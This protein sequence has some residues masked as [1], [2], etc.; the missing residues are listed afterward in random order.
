MPYITIDKNGKQITSY[1]GYPGKNVSGA[2]K[3][4][5][6]SPTEYHVLKIDY[7][8]FYMDEQWEISEELK[9]VADRET[10][11]KEEY[12]REH[13]NLIWNEVKK[14]KKKK[15]SA[16]DLIEVNKKIK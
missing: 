10:L 15:L 13:N 3:V 11:L 1:S 5:I 14:N 6:A 2:L 12:N 7:E 16:K 4:D 8:D 9:E